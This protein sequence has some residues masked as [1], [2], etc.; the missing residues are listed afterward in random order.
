MIPL[1]TAIL[2]GV[3]RSSD[4]TKGEFTSDILGAALLGAVPAG[5]V[6]D[7]LLRVNGMTHPQRCKFTLH[8]LHRAWPHIGQS[9]RYWPKLAEELERDRLIPRIKPLQD[10]YQAAIHVSLWKVITDMHDAG[11][12]RAATAEFLGRH[13][14]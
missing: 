9:V 12:S 4:W 2:R 14:L 10:K 5:A 11:E 1:S 6:P 13:G 8:E 7:F 3:E